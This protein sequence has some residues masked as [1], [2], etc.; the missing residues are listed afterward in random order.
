[1]SAEPRYQLTITRAQAEVLRD[2]CELLARCRLGQ[3]ADACQ[4]VL[5][6]HGQAV[7]PYD[8]A[9]DCEAAIKAEVG[10]APN[11][12][13]GVGKHP[14]ADL[15][16]DLYQV[17]RHRLAWDRALAEGHVRPGQARRWPEMMSVCY[18]EPLFLTH[19]PH[20][21]LHLIDPA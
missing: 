5:D 18:D 19:A 12:S 21:T 1:M 6:E 9:Q 17:L 14:A 10:L 20:P 2:A 7:V 15:P 4:Q 13:W 11:Q 3:I 16:W 8:L